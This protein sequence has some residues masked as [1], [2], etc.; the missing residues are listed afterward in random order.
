MAKPVRQDINTQQSINNVAISLPHFGVAMRQDNLTKQ[1]F[2]ITDSSS[3]E[4]I[5]PPEG[6]Q[7]MQAAIRFN[8]VDSAYLYQL[9]YLR[10]CGCPA[11]TKNRYDLIWRLVNPET[12]DIFK[13]E[14]RKELTAEEINRYTEQLGI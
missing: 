6:G 14:I 2:A 11:T 7:L 10:E 9:V 1:L 3:R 8:I 12:L 13:E 4:R 5:L